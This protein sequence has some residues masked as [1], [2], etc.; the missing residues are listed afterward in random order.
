M[1][2]DADM[3]RQVAVLLE[4][5]N[6]KLHAKVQALTHELARLR[7]HDAS[8][9]ERQLAFLKELLALREQALFG[10]SSEQRPRRPDP[11]AAPAPAPGRGHGPT[12]QPELPRVE[13]VHVLDQA[14]QTCPQCGGTLR[15]IAGQTEDA[16]EIT[17]LSGGSCS[18]PT[19][20]RSTGVRATGASTP[21][22]APY[23]SPRAPTS[24]AG[25]TRPAS[26]SRSRSASTS[27]ICRW[28][29]RRG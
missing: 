1:I 27:T 11:E 28:S 2:R 16:E 5:E 24:A 12:A 29:A 20:A 8:A 4:R 18:S 7:G 6:E 10:P 25:A 15:A 26:L 9:A 17:S 13:M 19:S 3:L 23:A 21:H 14:D 22:P